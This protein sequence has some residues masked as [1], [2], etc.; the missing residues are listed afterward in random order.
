LP[1]GGI[2]WVKECHLHIHSGRSIP[3]DVRQCEHVM[4]DAEKMSGMHLNPSMSI[5]PVDG[6]GVGHV[7]QQLGPTLKSSTS[8]LSRGPGAPSEHV[9]VWSEAAMASA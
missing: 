4:E 9:K 6:G 1:T 5:S 7:F 3:Y 2:L 8:I